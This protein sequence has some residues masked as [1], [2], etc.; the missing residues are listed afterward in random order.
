[1]RTLSI[2]AVAIGFF[3]GFAVPYALVFAVGPVMSVVSGQ[4]R[5]DLGAWFTL[6][7]LGVAFFAPIA[8]G[9]V[10]A[11]LAKVQPLLHGGV[12]GLLGIVAGIALSHSVESAV[13]AALIFGT[14]GVA[15]GWLWRMKSSGNSAP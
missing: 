1:V 11:R 6:L 5:V 9:Y 2:S 8:A 13:Y 14:G 3:A 10:A 12:V 4:E 15:G 7:W